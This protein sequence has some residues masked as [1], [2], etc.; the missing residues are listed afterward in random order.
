M[1]LKFTT[2]IF[3][4]ICTALITIGF[5]AAGIFKVLD[6]LIIQAILFGLLIGLMILIAAKGNW[7]IT[8]KENHQSND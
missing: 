7:S 3:A 5:F 2:D 8:E 4:I 1:R 6:Y